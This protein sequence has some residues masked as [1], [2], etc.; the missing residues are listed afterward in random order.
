MEMQSFGL[1]I[2]NHA[3]LYK[4]GTSLFKTVMVLLISLVQII[5]TI[6]E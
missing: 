1:M 6:S 2:K 3:K 5:S 4:E